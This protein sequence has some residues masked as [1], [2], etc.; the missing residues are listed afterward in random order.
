[1][2]KL[3]VVKKKIKTAM[4]KQRKMKKI[5]LYVSKPRQKGEQL[6]KLELKQI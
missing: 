2:R 6:R 3:F 5:V 1:M 4:I